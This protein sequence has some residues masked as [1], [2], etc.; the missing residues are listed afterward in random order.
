[1]R[2]IRSLPARPTSDGQAISEDATAAAQPRAG[3]ARA[4][5]R[6]KLKIRS[7]LCV[8]LALR[9]QASSSP[10]SL[11]CCR[12]MPPNVLE[13]C[14]IL[15]EHGFCASYL[16]LGRHVFPPSHTLP[17]LDFGKERHRKSGLSLLF[18]WSERRDLNPG[19]PVPQTGALTGLRYAPPGGRRCSTPHGPVVQGRRASETRFD[20]APNNA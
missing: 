5:A 15:E 4:L 2:T 8:G 10:A 1:M 11:P 19:P 14:I 12:L 18:C 16:L 9:C 6:I 13:A 17:K 7:R 20:R 3:F